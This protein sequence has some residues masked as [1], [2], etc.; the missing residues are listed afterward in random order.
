M[1]K[2]IDYTGK[3]VGRLTV[4]E[5][6]PTRHDVKG[7]PLIFWRC[8]CDCGRV[9][10]RHSSTL[11]ERHKNVACGCVRSEKI[12]AANKTRAKPAKE[13]AVTYAFRTYRLGAES[14]GL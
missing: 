10:D 6:L 9:T 11:G 14:R 2:F 3:K 4:L 8:L 7:R 5:Q 12:S 1:R 13:R